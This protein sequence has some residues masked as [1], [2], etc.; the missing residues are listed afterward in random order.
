M[1]DY[2]KNHSQFIMLTKQALETQS[3]DEIIAIGIGTN[4][5]EGI[6]MT[7]NN[8]GAKLLWVAK[9]GGGHPDWAIYCSFLNGGSNM[10]ECDENNFATISGVLALGEKITNERIIKSLVLC[11]AE[12]LEMYRR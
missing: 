10:M 11:D 2:I 8:L 3:P 4:S 9:R 12:A 6:F 7:N 5:P 1:A